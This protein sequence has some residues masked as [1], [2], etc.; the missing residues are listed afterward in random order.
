MTPGHDR[1]GFTLI[2]L[3]VVIAIIAILAAILFPV[4]AQARE[5]ARQTAC[6]SNLSQIAL[7]SVQYNQDYD[8]L[9][10]SHRDNAATGVGYSNPLCQQVGGPDT[11]DNGSGA[12]DAQI[13]DIACKR[14]FWAT[15]LQPYLKSYQVFQ[16]PDRQNSFA[17]AQTVAGETLSNLCGGTTDANSSGCGGLSYGAENSYGHN[18]G[19]LS[20]AGS[21]SSSGVGAPYVVGLNQIQRP[22]GTILC[23]DSTYYGA[24]P[25]V[26]NM[27][28]ALQ[29][30]GG[31]YTV[32]VDPQTGNTSNVDDIN[33][34]GLQSGAHTGQYE[35]Y[36]KNIGNSLY[37]YSTSSSGTWT[38]VVGSPNTQSSYLPAIAARHQ[39]LI[40]AAFVDG[41]VKALHYQDAVGNICYWAV[42]YHVT[43]NGKT[44]IGWHP[45]CN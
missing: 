23:L 29:T 22:S 27:S 40:N 28:G 37:G 36:W 33:F 34:F 7:A 45:F 19:W 10:Y 13:T 1:K 35:D 8:E 18:D 21:F 3:L 6:I 12:I 4:F 5:K 42:D 26:E 41:H 11:C 25:D 24:G 15:K 38:G 43:V 44:Y 32:T 16:C 14:T 20:P 31:A 39:S 9:M 30:Y 17:G 2:E